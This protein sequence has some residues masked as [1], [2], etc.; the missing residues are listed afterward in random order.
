MG[1]SKP[2]A[3]RVVMPSPTAPIV[4]QSIVP[5]QSYKDLAAQMQRYQKERR[6]IE[7]QRY[8][9]VGTPGEIGDRQRARDVKTEEAYLASLPGRE[10]AGSGTGRMMAQ[11]SDVS[12]TALSDARSQYRAAVRRVN[13]VPAPPKTGKPSWADQKRWK[14]EMDKI[15]MIKLGN[16]K[17]ST[18]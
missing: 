13:K 16:K 8:A 1:G 9:E 5:E 3:P 10:P 18:Q 17:K 12:E 11:P 4:F 15:G 6:E 7:K 14:G 2:S